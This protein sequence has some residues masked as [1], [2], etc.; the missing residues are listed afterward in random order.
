MKCL[1]CKKA[2]SE[3]QLISKKNFFCLESDYISLCKNCLEPYS[4]LDL[5]ALLLL[6]SK[7]VN[8]RHYL[9]DDDISDILS[10]IN[11]SPYITESR[12][13]VLYKL[14]VYI[15]IKFKGRQY[16]INNNIEEFVNMENEQKIVQ[17]RSEFYENSKKYTAIYSDLES[18]I[19][20]IFDLER[21]DCKT[22]VFERESMEIK[23][24]DQNYIK[25]MISIKT[26][27]NELRDQI[28]NITRLEWIEQG[29]FYVVPVV[30]NNKMYNL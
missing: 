24:L 29:I 26:S 10:E 3:F 1:R 9:N 15:G 17:L 6:P 16:I 25:S 8:L 12:D 30:L 18:G 4:N 2:K 7:V 20:G 19:I 28:L 11:R 27:K 21:E 22:I 13:E 14:E 5:S 23:N